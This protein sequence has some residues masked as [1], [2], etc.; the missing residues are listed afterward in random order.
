[1]HDGT[2]P[3]DRSFLPH[4]P[5]LF[6]SRDSLVEVSVSTLWESYSML[7]LW[8][9]FAWR[10]KFAC[11]DMYPWLD[12]KLCEQGCRRPH[13]DQR[14]TLI[15][16]GLCEGLQKKL[17]VGGPPT[18][19]A[20]HSACADCILCRRTLVIVSRSRGWSTLADENH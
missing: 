20:I 18:Q 9:D 8:I 7:S 14:P 5:N 6:K 16:F 1:M 15:D 11:M 10:F 2:L 13:V 19:K 12:G 17:Q 4:A 3:V